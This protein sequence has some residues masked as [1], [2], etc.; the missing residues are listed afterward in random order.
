MLF[1]KRSLEGYVEVDHSNSPGI[2]AEQAASVGSKLVVPSGS[3]FKSPTMM[4]SK[5]Q[6]QI[7]LNPDRSR[8]RGYCRKCDHDVCD[9]C[10][11]ML[12][13]GHGC[14]AETCWHLRLASLT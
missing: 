2:T 5:C 13:L 4:C 11:L 14:S 6:Y 10:S 9:R 1:S 12:K 8:S 3:V 7:I